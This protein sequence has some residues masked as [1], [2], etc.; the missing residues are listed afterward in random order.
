MCRTPN[1]KRVV[2]PITGNISKI[3]I[4][5]A[6]RS[7]GGIES[8]TVTE[9]F[10]NANFLNAVGKY[11][12]NIVSL[13]FTCLFEQYHAEAIVNYTP[14]LR[15]LSIRHFLVSMRGLCHVLNSLE[16]L[17]VVNLCHCLITDLLEG[18]FQ[19]YSIDDL[20]ERVDFSC[21]LIICKENS[22]L[23]CTN[24]LR[25]DRGRPSYENMEDIWRED[26]IES[27]A[28]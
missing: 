26:E 27:L 19:A 5:I 22:C 28:H 25:N 14:N 12:K 6:M 20:R 10:N 2:L 11:C 9:M 3:G 17:E 18:S 8:I 15:T 21:E 23:R 7:W 24:R 1:L 16:H 13:K 4:E